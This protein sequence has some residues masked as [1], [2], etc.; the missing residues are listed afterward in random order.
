MH[1]FLLEIRRNVLLVQYF[2]NIF[3]KF[4][5]EIRRQVS[6]LGT[7]RARFGGIRWR[8]TRC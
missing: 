4:L 5:C 2:S 6:R 7:K 3:V 8:L 1:K